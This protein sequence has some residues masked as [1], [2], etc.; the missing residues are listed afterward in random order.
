MTPPS[1]PSRPSPPLPSRRL[2]RAAGGLAAAG[3]AIST[4]LAITRLAGEL[5]ACGP[6]QG[7]EQVATSEYSAVLGIPLAVL[8]LG[9]SL[10]ILALVVAWARTGSQLAVLGAYGLG[11]MGIVVV[12]YLTYLELFVIHA[13]CAWCVAYAAT[14]ILGWAVIAWGVRR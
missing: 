3:A 5:P 6:L 10:A 4:Y 2:A 11:L 1:R 14:V 9:F 7:C 13:V 8:G 12:A